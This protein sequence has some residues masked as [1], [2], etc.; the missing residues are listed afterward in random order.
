[1]AENS[2]IEWTTHTFNP[3]RG[4]T[5]VSPGCANCYAETMSKRNPK[6]LGVWGPQGKRVV[7]AESQWKLS[8]KWDREAKEAGERHRVFCASL[9]DV[10]EDWR[11]A[12]VNAKGETMFQCCQCRH[13]WAADVSDYDPAKG[14]NGIICQECLSPGPNDMTMQ[15]VRRRLFDLID[16]TRNL[17][18]LLLTKRPENIAKMVPVSLLCSIED[19]QIG[20]PTNPRPNVWLGVSVEDR[21]HGLPRLEHLQSAPAAMRFLSVEPLLG[22]LGYID[23]TGIHWVI[24][25]GESGPDARPCNVSWIRSIIKQC[26]ATSLPCFVKQVGA[27]IIDRNDSGFDAE[28]W[29]HAEGPEN[30]QPVEKRAWPTPLDVEH[31]IHGFREEYQG[32]DVRVRLRDRKGGDMEEWPADLRVREFP[33]SRL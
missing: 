11:G 22:D 21:K 4:C 31:D 12:M 17:D 15:D 27:H 30:G 9:A 20:E 23:L 18:W 1:M 6:T 28:T 13:V 10:F 24:V 19:G 16:R 3:W 25:G 32:A 29:T 26:R 14:D 2:S 8:L 33:K 7:A 5:K